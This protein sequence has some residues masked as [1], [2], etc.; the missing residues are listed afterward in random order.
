M[1]HENAGVTYGQPTKK[2]GLSHLSPSLK[3]KSD[4]FAFQELLGI[5]HSFLMERKF[6]CPERIDRGFGKKIFHVDVIRNKVLKYES[7]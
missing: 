2:C 1:L 6:F 3:M 4:A 5:H 7:L